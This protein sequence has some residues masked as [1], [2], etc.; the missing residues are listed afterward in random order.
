MFVAPPPP[1]VR[2]S[3]SPSPA[4]TQAGLSAAVRIPSASPKQLSLSPYA[5]RLSI[6]SGV[7]GDRAGLDG[8]SYVPPEISPF[9]SRCDFCVESLYEIEGTNYAH[10]RVLKVEDDAVR[11]RKFDAQLFSSVVRQL[12]YCGF[13]VARQEDVWIE[14]RPGLIES[15]SIGT[16]RTQLGRMTPVVLDAAWPIRVRVVVRCHQLD[17]VRV[18]QALCDIHR[19]S[20]E[21]FSHALRSLKGWFPPGVSHTTVVRMV[22]PDAEETPAGPLTHGK[23]S[24]MSSTRAGSPTPPWVTV[25]TYD[26]T[27]EDY[28][29]INQQKQAESRRTGYVRRV[30][31]SKDRDDDED[32]EVVPR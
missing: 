29:R 1:L 9:S 14:V 3:Q 23:P 26:L 21:L 12:S 5:R 31:A 7:R 22:P 25:D 10:Y 18:S 27:D 13:S 32:D 17:G 20:G 19:G 16:A 24:E 6:S 11:R 15:I 8:D 28:R 4:R 30:E 2:V